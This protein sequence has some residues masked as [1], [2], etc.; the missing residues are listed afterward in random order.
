MSIRNRKRIDADEEGNDL[1]PPPEDSPVHAVMYLLEWARQRDFQ[2]G[3][4]VQIGDVIVQVADRRQQRGTPGAPDRG[5]W[6]AHGHEQ[7]DE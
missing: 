5:V 1:K 6:A 7:G 3:P 2:I 4:M